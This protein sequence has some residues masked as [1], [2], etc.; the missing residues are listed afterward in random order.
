MTV[1]D[2]ETTGVVGSL[3]SEPWQVGMVRMT[4][5]RVDCSRQFESLL[6][7]GDRPFNPKAPG[8]HHK[9]RE[10]IA[11]A[12]TM[13]ELWPELRPWWLDGPLGAHNVSVEKN[14]V[15]AA[16]PMHRPGPWIDS[17]KLARI[18]YPRLES[19]SLGNLLE[20]LDLLERT[21][22]CCPGREPHDALFDAV[23][24]AFLLEWLLSLDGWKNVTIAQ[25]EAAQPEA[26]H[27]ILAE[28]DARTR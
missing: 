28:R 23:G 6:R 17:L 7:V 10:Q 14:I 12:P 3:P 8:N 9:R 19:H 2:F 26:Y 27:R 22:E 20:R 1:I 11:S 18:A 16:A 5:G 24:C 21:R 13:G 15:C 4:G 25:L